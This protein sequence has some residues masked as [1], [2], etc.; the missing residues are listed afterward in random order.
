MRRA[1]L[2][3]AAAG[4]VGP[5]CASAPLDDPRVVA[6]Q[7][8]VCS[9]LAER[10]RWEASSDPAAYQRAYDLQDDWRIIWMPVRLSRP[11]P[12][13]C[14]KPANGTDFL[15]FDADR[16]LAELSR[17]TPPG[18]LNCFFERKDGQWRA[19]GCIEV[20]IMVEPVRE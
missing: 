2:G 20:Y 1:I 18:Y 7:A 3:L 16:G 10:P 8:E 4:L 13:S 11:G 9:V 14:S 5:G 12:S 15:R 6:F 17:T 19:V